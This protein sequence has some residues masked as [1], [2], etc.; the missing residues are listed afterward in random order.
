MDAKKGDRLVIDL[1]KVGQARRSG[2]VLRVEG[3]EPHQRLWVRWEDG[4][5]S[6]FMPGPWGALERAKRD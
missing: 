6:L 1:T 4:D 5:E 2:E 3:S